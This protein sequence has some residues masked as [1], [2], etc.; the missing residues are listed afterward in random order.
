MSGTVIWLF[1][2]GLSI[3]CGLTWDI[4]KKCESLSRA[5][6]VGL[7]KSQ[8]AEAMQHKSVNVA[9][10]SDFLRHLAEK[11]ESGKQHL[12]VTTNWD[13]L[14]QQEILNLELEVRPSWLA[15]SQVY[16]INGSIEVLENNSNRSPF[17][18]PNDLAVHR[19]RSHEAESVFEKMIWEKRFVVVGMAFE[20]EADKFLFQAL[21]RVEDDLPIGDSYWTIVNPDQKFLDQCKSLI[22]KNI[23]NA[24]IDCFAG[25]FDKWMIC[26]MPQIY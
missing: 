15:N 22:Q 20:C 14:L 13:Y 17:I 3:G 5:E 2:R 21:G 19:V 16:H 1:G 25:T 6:M 9:S 10:I 11:T 12:F 8:L 26:G 4:P 24:K 23:P 18:L 7:I